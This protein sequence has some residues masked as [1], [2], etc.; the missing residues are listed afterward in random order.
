[1]RV[2]PRIRPVGQRRPERGLG[3]AGVALAAVATGAQRPSVLSMTERVVLSCTLA[4]LVAAGNAVANVM[5]RKA[6]LEEPA[7]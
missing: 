5:Q 1:M 7:D 4:V 3:I 2:T 6:S